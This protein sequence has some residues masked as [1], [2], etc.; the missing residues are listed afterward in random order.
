MQ[1]TTI[2]LL[3]CLTLCGA[4]NVQATVESLDRSRTEFL[5]P[6]KLYGEHLIVVQGGLGGV[7]EQ[8]LLIDTG[9]YPSAID[10]EVAHKLRLKVNPGESRA[11]GRN[12]PAGATIIPQVEIGPIRAMGLPVIVEDLSKLSADLGIRIDA[13]IGVDVLARVNFRVDYTEKELAF[14][15]PDHLAFSAP[16]EPLR[17]MACVG[18]A[19][20][21]TV[22]RLLIDTGA[23]KTVL[24]TQRVPWLVAKAREDMRFTSLSGRLRLDEVR[25]DEVEIGGAKVAPGDVFLSD[26]ANMAGMPFDGV[27]ATRGGNFRRI[28]FDFENNIFSWDLD[29]TASPRRPLPNPQLTAT[30]TGSTP[31]IAAAGSTADIQQDSLRGSGLESH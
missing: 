31:A 24:F 8:H 4:V 26:G 6:L 11:F 13:L 1:I 25:L 22:V 2:V 10:A 9:A 19:I 12:I 16:I 20:H 17:G 14:G 3:M 29:G 28:A 23:A 27:M 5:L 18:V 30:Q 7:P 21:G 15:A